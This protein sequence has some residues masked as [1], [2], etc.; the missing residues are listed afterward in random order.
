MLSHSVMPISFVTPWTVAHQAP[1]SIGFPRQGF[2]T[3]LPLPPPG[4]LLDPGIKPAPPGL[5]QCRQILYPLSHQGSP[6]NFYTYRKQRTVHIKK[7]I[8]RIPLKKKY[9][10]LQKCVCILFLLTEC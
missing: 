9:V 10:V 1:L 4:D 6:Q 8:Y 2:H 3:G 5:L 7:K